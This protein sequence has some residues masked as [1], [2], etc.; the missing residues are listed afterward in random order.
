L[1]AGICPGVILGNLIY[2]YSEFPDDR[3]PVIQW[4]SKEDDRYAHG[5]AGKGT[6][7]STCHHQICIALIQVQ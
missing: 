7:E 4:V 6:V 2:F 3:N 5:N 1:F